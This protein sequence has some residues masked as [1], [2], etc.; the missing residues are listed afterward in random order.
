MSDRFSELAFDADGMANRKRRYF[1]FIRSQRLNWF[2]EEGNY[3]PETE[4]DRR[5]TFWVFPALVSSDNPAEREWALSFYA[6]EPAWDRYDVFNS[7]VV[8]VN[9]V[10]E[11][12]YLT[13]EL[14]LKSEEHLARFCSIDGG[15]K[16]CACI[17]DYTF[18]GYNDNMPALATRQLILAGDVLDRPEFTDAGLFRLEGLCAHFQRRGMLSEHTSA[19]YLPATLG[20]LMDTAECTTHATAREM[21]LACAQ[22][23][24]LDVLCHFH[25][26]TGTLGGV[27]SRAYT[28]DLLGGLSMVN[29]LLWYLTGHPLL[30][31][32]VEALL[33]ESFEGPIHHGGCRA[34]NAAGQ[35]DVFSPSYQ[36]LSRE[37]VNFARAPRADEHVVRATTDYGPSGNK[38]NLQAV[39]ATTTAFHRKLWCL[40]SNSS[41]NSHWTQKTCLQGTVATTPTPASW[42]DRLNFW[43]YLCADQDYGQRVPNH[44]GQPVEID[45]V[46]NIGD[47]RTL[48]KKGS[49]MSL[50]LISP[51]QDDKQ[52]SE[53]R[54]GIIFGTCMRMPDE[55]FENTDRLTAWEGTT[56]PTSWQ[57]L[58]FGDVY[59]G[60]RAVGALGFDST[61][62]GTL[63]PP[64]R[65][66]RNR[67]LRFEL[68]LLENQKIR[69][70]PSFRWKTH[71][72][73]VIEVSDVDQCGSFEEFRRQCQNGTWEYYL[74][75]ARHARYCGRN[76][77][78][79]I[80]DAPS[81][82]TVK[83]MSIDGLIP[84]PPRLLEATGLDPLLVDLFPD[85]HRI[86]LRRLL[87]DSAYSGTPYYPVEGLVL[88]TK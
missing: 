42:R 55:I 37:I 62:K 83:V 9:L 40:A 36:L 49:A 26:G 78:F 22:R 45:H 27:Q 85:G 34:F 7:S 14:I 35:A 56:T 25:Q 38:T 46:N 29:A 66:I 8:A 10:R 65:V 73:C 13:P 4:N 67:Y 6:R 63:V 53:L 74:L 80:S 12:K 54:Y 16:P 61:T 71:F 48:Q 18:Q 44:L 17:N 28:V 82:G 88:L 32:P 41:G 64:R 59:V 51:H 15:R 2:T 1:E 70:N 52:F 21:A 19:T 39:S 43:E 77:E 69:A 87:F 86:R 23:V 3:R 31:D 72:G 79:Y 50:G 68:P 58:R 60:L 33:S 30:I 75:G 84:E 11:Q 57:F 47:F 20:C 81:D 5:I 24:L 76:G